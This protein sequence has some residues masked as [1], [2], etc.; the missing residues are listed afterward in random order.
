[1]F[2]IKVIRNWVRANAAQ[3]PLVR[4][5]AALT[6]VAL[7]LSI[8]LVRQGAF[9]WERSVEAQGPT[10]VTTPHAPSAIVPPP[11]AQPTEM[12]SEVSTSGQGRQVFIGFDGLPFAIPTSPL[13]ENVPL[14][15]LPAT[16][17]QDAVFSSDPGYDVV[18]YGRNYGNPQ[19]GITRAFRGMAD[20]FAPL[21]VDFPNKAND[22]SFTILG[23]DNSGVIATVEIYQNGRWSQNVPLFSPGSSANLNYALTFHDITRIIVR[24]NDSF[25]LA[26]DNF[27]FTVPDPSPSPTPTP[28]A[29]PTP[30]PPPDINDLIAKPEENEIDLFWTPSSGA[31]WYMIERFD[32]AASPGIGQ[33]ASGSAAPPE[34]LSFAPIN[35]TFF[36]NTTP[37][38][39]YEDN[40][41]GTGLSFEREYFY[42]VTPINLAGQGRKSNVAKGIPLANACSNQ[43]ANA[44]SGDTGRFG[45]HMHYE[46]SPDDGL[47]LSNVSL[48]GKPMANR[49]SVPYF[50]LTPKG[51]QPI[52]GQLTPAASGNTMRSHLLYMS[53]PLPEQVDKLAFI[54]KY[55]IDHIPGMPKA[56]LTIMETF[57]FYNNGKFTGPTDL[58]ASPCE[59]SGLV[60]P[61]SKF[62]PMIDYS[63]ESRDGAALES[64]M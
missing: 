63:I 9:D 42:V 5:F 17:Y 2:A 35:S 64:I 23:V 30:T 19:P 34:S 59:P 62:R 41:S 32:Q 48:N 52:R 15:P 20:H 13:L 18:T 26:F 53:P 50:K 46:T 47:V 44:I 24:V 57:E 4:I 21:I 45:W 22:L 27:R 39:T 10:L 11:D 40:D 14:W 37:L 38:C 16:Q 8:A 29:S 7:T 36:C 31:G 61:C 54:A 43:Q 1:M 12:N 58:P 25:G 6:L 60:Q 51:G 49:I 3:L 56:C 55:G 33:P 28:A